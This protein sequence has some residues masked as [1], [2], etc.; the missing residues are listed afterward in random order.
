MTDA[1]INEKIEQLRKLEEQAAD[2]KAAA[3][4]IREGLKAELDTRKVDSV[5]TGSHNVFWF[6]YEKSGIDTDKSLRR[7]GFMICIRRN[8]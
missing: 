4:E 8:L 5:N 6:C 2:L 7:Q 1:M 3:D